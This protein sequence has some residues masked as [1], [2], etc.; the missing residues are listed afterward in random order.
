MVSMVSTLVSTAE[1]N[2][3]VKS[4]K[5]NAAL[6]ANYTEKFFLKDLDVLQSMLIH[7]DNDN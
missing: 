6:C 4:P 1:L 3:I 7:T 2:R 5:T